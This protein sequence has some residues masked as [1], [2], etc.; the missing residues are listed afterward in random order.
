MSRA[1]YSFFQIL[2]EWSRQAFVN[3]ALVTVVLLLQ[4]CGQKGDLYLPNTQSIEQVEASVD[5]DKE[6][7]KKKQSSYK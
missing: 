6:S 2:K 4:A 1:I 7:D 3:T 5:S